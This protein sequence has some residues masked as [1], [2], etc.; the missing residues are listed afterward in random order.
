MK[1]DVLVVNILASIVILLGMT[2]YFMFKNTGESRRAD[3]SVTIMVNERGY[4][5]SLIQVAAGK[6]LK[7]RV[8]RENAEACKTSIEFPQFN[9]AYPFMLDIPINI[10]FPPLARGTVDFD[11]QGSGK[12]GR[13]II[14]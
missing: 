6:P 7:L 4:Q 12:H 1:S 14:I 10:S 13:I 3:D 5:P 8:I 2:A 11:C 9:A